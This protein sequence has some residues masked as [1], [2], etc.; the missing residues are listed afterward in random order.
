MKAKEENKWT[1]EETKQLI[2]FNKQ[3]EQLWNHNLP[4][5]TDRILKKLNYKKLNEI[6]P[7][8]SQDDLNKQWHILKTIFYRELKREEGTKV[9]GMGTDCVYTSQW[10]F[11]KALMFV[12]GSDDV[13]PSVTTLEI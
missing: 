4:P 12:K 2:E 1:D 10:K 13:D 7:G 11:F 3:N 6:I 9:S 8:H 5:P